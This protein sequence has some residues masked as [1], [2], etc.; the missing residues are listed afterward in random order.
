MASYFYVG[1]NYFNRKNGYCK[2]GETSLALS[3]RLATIRQKEHFECVGYIKF[4][5]ASKAERLYVESYVRLMIE[6]NLPD[7]EHT[8]NDHFIYSID[9]DKKQQIEQFKNKAFEYAIKA[10]EFAGIKYEIG[11]KQY[12]RG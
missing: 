11:T 2:I 6:K 10:C 9:G 1:Y 5:N 12:K 4:E 7:F 8:Q 3:V